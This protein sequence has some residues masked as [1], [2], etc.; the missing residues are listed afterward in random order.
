MIEEM[1][2]LLTL[3]ILPSEKLAMVVRI[4]KMIVYNHD[5]SA[6]GFDVAFHNL[7]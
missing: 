6:I 3:A 7:H 5:T 2:M 1:C 4:T